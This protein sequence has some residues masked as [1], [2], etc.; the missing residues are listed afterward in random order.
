MPKF[1]SNHIIK[2]RRRPR[3]NNTL[4]VLN[5]VPTEPES[6]GLIV[7]TPIKLVICWE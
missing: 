2:R 3:F 1:M 7:E 5:I 6:S 4:A